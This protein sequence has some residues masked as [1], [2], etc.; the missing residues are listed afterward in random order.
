MDDAKAGRFKTVVVYSLCR[1]GRS[2]SDV[3][4]QVIELDAMGVRFMTITQALDTNNK[5]PMARFTLQLF[6]ALAEFEVDLTTERIQDGVEHAREFGTK[7]GKPIGRPRRVFHHD[8]VFRLKIEGLSIR[9]IADRLG[10]GKGTVS[11][12]LS[13]NQDRGARGTD[14]Q[15]R[16]LTE[17]VEAS[18][19]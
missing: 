8:E 6:A 12:C 7:S 2:L 3:I 10:I 17:A 13:Q 4:R 16:E 15:A 14:N 11:R 18:L 19:N 9:Q 1:F 5:S